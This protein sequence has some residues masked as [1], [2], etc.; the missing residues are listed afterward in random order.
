MPS[1]NGGRRTVESAAGSPECRP[2]TGIRGRIGRTAKPAAAADALAD[3]GTV[4]GRHIL[5]HLPNRLRGPG[6]P[7]VLQTPWK[8]CVTSRHDVL[9][10]SGHKA[11]KFIKTICLLL[12]TAA[13]TCLGGATAADAIG[14][15]KNTTQ[16]PS[17]KTNAIRLDL[18]SSSFQPPEP[19]D[20]AMKGGTFSRP[21][22]TFSP[23]EG[24]FSRP[25]TSTI[26]QPLPPTSPA[27]AGTFSRPTSTF[28]VP[29]GGTFSRPS[30]TFALPLGGT[31]SRPDSTFTNSTPTFDAITSTFPSGGEQFEK[32]S[33]V[34]A[35]S[36]SP[37]VVLDFPPGTTVRKPVVP[38]TAKK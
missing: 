32:A 33:E 4:V 18:P 10:L 22:P 19:I 31:F 27:P 30:S 12:G 29:T 23:P 2:Q 34:N 3:A 1:R 5:Q 8:S 38:G 21:A 11:N 28:A 25:T 36:P 7:F 37:L 6:N 20:P 9:Q 14:K 13:L 24:T 26:S 35:P 15:P 17:V 16:V